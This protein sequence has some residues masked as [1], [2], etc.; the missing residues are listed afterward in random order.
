VSALIANARMYA[1]NPAVRD[2]WRAL[3]DWVGRHSG[4]PL[5]YL[6]HAAPA[7]HRCHPE[8]GSAVESLP[9]RPVSIGCHGICVGFDAPCVSL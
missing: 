7:P 8:L 1:V 4:I 9:C 3:L 5:T 2:P 6:E